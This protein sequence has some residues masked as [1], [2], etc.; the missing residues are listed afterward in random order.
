M[1]APKKTIVGASLSIGA[2]TG[3]F[4]ADK[5]IN[6]GTNRWSIRPEVAISQPVGK[7]WLIDVYAGVWFF[8]TNSTF[9]PG[10]ATRSQ[11]PMGAFQAHV[12]YNIT[13]RFWVAYNTTYYTGGRSSIDGTY[14]SDQQSNTR[15]GVTAVMPVGKANSIKFAASTGAVVRVGQDFTTFSLGWQHAW[16]TGE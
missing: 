9:Y 14:N 13:P 4:H 8:T 11:E 10:S 12:S 7:R 5:L 6:I 16:I 15:I 2:P 3:Q 1:N